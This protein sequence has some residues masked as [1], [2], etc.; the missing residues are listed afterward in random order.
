MWKQIVT[1]VSAVAFIQTWI[2]EADGQSTWCPP[3]ATPVAGGG[4]NMCLCPDGSYANMNGCP[5]RYI[6]QQPQPYIPPQQ[7]I[8]PETDLQVAGAFAS[9]L[10]AI[11]GWRSSQQDRVMDQRYDVKTILNEQQKKN[12]F[13]APP[14]PPGF[15]EKNYEPPPNPNVTPANPFGISGNLL[16]VQGL[17]PTARPQATATPAPP[18]PPGQLGVNAGVTGFQQQT[19]ATANNQSWSQKATNWFECSVLRR[20]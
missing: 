5:Q 7:P 2:I 1:A 18:P 6:G 11:D 4:G 8:M 9:F 20:C 16:D 17:A 12:S 10:S 13:V 19:N 15:F 3:G 14:A